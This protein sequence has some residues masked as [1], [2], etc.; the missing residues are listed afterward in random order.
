MVIAYLMWRHRLPFNDAF[1]RCKAGRGVTSPNSGFIAALLGLQEKL[2]DGAPP[3]AGRLYRTAPLEAEYTC[4]WT[5]ASAR[6]GTY[7][8][9]FR[10][11]RCIRSP[12]IHAVL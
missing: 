11:T 8:A 1:A 9:V 10:G 12:C 5:P 3:A 4:S 6:E 2:T 7:P